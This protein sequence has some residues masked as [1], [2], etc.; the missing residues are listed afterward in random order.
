MTI[1]FR[2]EGERQAWDRYVAGGL[3]SHHVELNVV[4][5]ADGL[6]LVRRE[7]SSALGSSS[8]ERG[9]GAAVD[10]LVHLRG[11]FVVGDPRGEVLTEAIDRLTR[12]KEGFPV[13]TSPHPTGPLSPTL[14]VCSDERTEPCTPDHCVATGCPFKEPP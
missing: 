1:E 14:H 13:G 2:D 7:R 3:S 4:E 5:H 12:L 10:L 9:R 6:L 8:W 11:R